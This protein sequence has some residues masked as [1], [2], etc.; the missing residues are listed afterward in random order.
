MNHALGNP[1]H[2]PMGNRSPVHAPHNLYSCGER[3]EGGGEEGGEEGE[4]DR[5]QW[6]AIAVTNDAQW[7]G[8]CQALGKPELEDDPRFRDAPA[9]KA[10][11][12]ALDEIVAAWCARRERW[13]ITRLL[14]AV[15]VP[16]FPSLDT[17][18]LMED[19]HIQG[20]GLL[21][22]WPHP[23]VGTRTL[24]GM[25]WRFSN[26]PNNLGKAAPLLG[27]DTDAVLER[28]LGMDEARRADL[29]ARG[30]IE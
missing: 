16:A 5:E 15:G 17:P 4:T 6:V 28:L 9:R 27:E 24:V 30:I 18:S 23:E 2:A 14:Q 1:P 7:R 8:L 29:R 12:D 10:H 11:E 21:T 13:E 26:R 19:P 22:H 25:P 3:E 20:R